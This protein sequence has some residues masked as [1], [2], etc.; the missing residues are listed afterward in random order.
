M[1]IVMKLIILLMMYIKLPQKKVEFAVPLKHLSN[2]WR[3]SDMLLIN[4]EVSLNLAWSKN[5][6]TDMPAIASPTN[7]TF[8]LTDTK[9][10]VPA[11]TLSTENDFSLV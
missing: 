5:V 6:L 3:N 4:Y 9:L 2:F 11:L 7:A 8:N 1:W 10:Y